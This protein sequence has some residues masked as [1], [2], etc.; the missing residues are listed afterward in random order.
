MPWLSFTRD[1]DWNPVRYCGRVT[2]AF[3]GGSRVLAN[4]HAAEA[5][6]AAGAAIECGRLETPAEV[7]EPEDGR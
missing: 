4:R 6:I 2:V 1:F 7:R 3:K 5:A